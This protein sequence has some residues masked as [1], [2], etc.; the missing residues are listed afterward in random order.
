MRSLLCAGLALPVLLLAAPAWADSDGYYCVGPDYLAYQFGLAAP[1]VAPHRL[2]VVRLGGEQGMAEPTAIQIPQFQVHGMLC[3]ERT[4]QLEA[5]D[6]LYTV[7]LDASRHPVRYE[8]APLDDAQKHLLSGGRQSRLGGFGFSTK[9]L[10]Q[11]RRP[12]MTD[13]SGHAFTLEI[14]PRPS[15]PNRCDTEI[16]TRLLESDVSRKVV[17]EQVVFRGKGFIVDC[18]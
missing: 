1:P 4:V 17:R 5:F 15:G 13:A 12:L 3:G 11:E 9:G 10:A 8:T 18:N 7:R 14:E 2:Y 6:A 16:T